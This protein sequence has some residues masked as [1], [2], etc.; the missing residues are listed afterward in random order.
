[1]KVPLHLG[2]VVAYNNS[3]KTNLDTKHLRQANRYTNAIIKLPI[4]YLPII[5]DAGRV[6]GNSRIQLP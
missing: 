6:P 3:G 4:R 2:G 5:E 1:M